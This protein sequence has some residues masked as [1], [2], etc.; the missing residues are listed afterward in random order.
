VSL[1]YLIFILTLLQGSIIYV[2]RDLTV[3]WKKSQ[4]WRCAAVELWLLGH[5]FNRCATLCPVSLQIS[6]LKSTLI[7]CVLWHY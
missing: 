4:Q 7:V 5:S 2:L 1:N 6:C 3:C